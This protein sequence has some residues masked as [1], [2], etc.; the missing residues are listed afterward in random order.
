MGIERDNRKVI[1]ELKDRIAE[2]RR[3]G[4]SGGIDD[5]EM[6][7]REEATQA[8]AGENER[9][10]VDFVE[11]CVAQSVK[12]HADLRETQWECYMTFLEH[13]PPGYELKAAWQSRTVIPKPFGAVQ[14]GASTVQ[15]AFSPDFLSINDEQNELSQA[16]W[17]AVMTQQLSPRYS[18]FVIKLVDAV[19]MCLAV[20][21]SME[22]IPRYTSADGLRIDLAEP[23]KIL[24]DPDAPP[25]DPHG[26]MYWIHEEWL[27]YW[28][29]KQAEKAGQYFNIDNAKDTG[30]A[31]PN[32]PFMTKEAIARRK[33]Q[34]WQRSRFRT[35]MLVREFWGVVLDRHGN[36]LLPKARLSVCGDRV[37]QKPAA[38]PYRRLRW[39]GVSF[40][41]LPDLLSFGGRG[42]IHGIMSIWEAMCNIMCLHEDALKWVVNPET[43]ISV[44]DLVDPKDIEGWP[45]KKYLTRGTP[46]GQQ[47]VR[48]INRP[49]KTSSVLAN[50]AYYDQNFQ[51]GSFVTDAVQGLPGYRQDMTW[52]E[53][54][55]NLSQAMGVFTMMGRNIEAG[56]I[57]F[58][59]AAMDVIQT[60]ATPEDFVS[61]L[62][63]KEIQELAQL[64]GEFPEM[65]GEFSISGIQAM[66]KDMDTLKTLIT[67]IVPMS[68]DPGYGAF[69]RKYKVLKAIERRANL[70]DEDVVV[71]DA[72]AQKILRAQLQA[73]Q[74]QAAWES[75]LARSGSMDNG[76]PEGQ[77]PGSRAGRPVEDLNQQPPGPAGSSGGQNIEGEPMS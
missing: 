34:M 57:A 48:T 68:N 45:G 47:V 2:A 32:N 25:R 38:V 7:E 70:E 59:E 44:Y 41:A 13:E 75:H 21:Q 40:S 33:G 56:A 23:W 5:Q 53:S 71:D 39:P 62:K 1:E 65:S 76:T 55:Q 24:R 19:T 54:A 51:R 52:R 22:M 17:R 72:T 26:G 14:Y 3:R 35:A 50:L 73:A 11:D 37:I 15:K 66:L 10:F 12:A 43:E 6:A 31:D 30:Q 27:D 9:H 77:G 46:H 60:F 20:G 58:V 28:M 63:P 64:G 74:N 42:L 61:L 16:F 36:M 49:D 4:M 67:T 18:N 69:I 8:Y 29:L